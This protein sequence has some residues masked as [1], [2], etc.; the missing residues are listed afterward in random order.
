MIVVDPSDTGV[1]TPDAESTVATE[2]SELDQEAVPSLFEVGAGS[3]DGLSKT[4]IPFSTN[5]PNVGVARSIVR[6][7][8]VEPVA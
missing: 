5:A 7:A 6:I 2:V 3:A 8:V 1:T 4:P